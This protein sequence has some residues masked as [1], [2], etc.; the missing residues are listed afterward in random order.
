MSLTSER[1]RQFYSSLAHMG[2]GSRKWPEIR[3][4][5]GKGSTGFLKELGGETSTSVLALPSNK[6][7]LI[8][9]LEE[10]LG[11][12]S[13][14]NRWE[15]FT[16]LYRR[17]LHQ[18]QLQVPN[19]RYLLLMSEAHGVLL[20]VD[21]ETVMAFSS[22][23][24]E[25][26]ERLLTKFDFPLLSTLGLG[27]SNGKTLRRSALELAQW[28][29]YWCTEL[30][31]K[32]GE[33]KST[34]ERFFLTLHLARL[35]DTLGREPRE[36]VFLAPPP[37]R[38]KLAAMLEKLFLPIHQSQNILQMGGLEDSLKFA[39]S[40]TDLEALMESYWCL[41]RNKFTAEVFA[42]AFTAP[43]FL[44]YSYQQYMTR[45]ASQPASDAGAAL[46][47][48]I[49]QAHEIPVSVNLDETG[50][51]VLL[52]EFDGLVERLQQS[53]LEHQASLARGERPG[54]QLDLLLAEPEEP[55]TTNVVTVA[56][57]DLFSF[58]TVFPERVPSARLALLARAVEWNARLS[59]KRNLVY[60]ALKA[61]VL[62]PAQAPKRVIR[63]LRGELN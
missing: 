11:L 48:L 39:R 3:T 27:H 14:F 58:E 54:L 5:S 45:G 31:S 23:K 17:L 12:E 42:E 37:P 9:S 63:P 40:I 32:S 49:A 56:L 21:S 25:W 20:E 55:S 44:G 36:R 52:K 43:D 7:L 4:G 24:R 26:E 47:M 18:A 10:N 30:G 16:P 35:V 1:I 61:L 13:A 28:T 8:C 2:W 41:S 46:N 34:V 33:S 62:P 38:T 29:T 6:A 19:A 50:I 57:R 51:V 60:P 53:A 59:N 15:D 22:G